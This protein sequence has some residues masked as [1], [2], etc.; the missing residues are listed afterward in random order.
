MFI[1]FFRI[2]IV[3]VIVDLGSWEALLSLIWLF[4]LDLFDKSSLW[5]KM[6]S[7]PGRIMDF[8][9]PS[10]SRAS[11]APKYYITDSY[12]LTHACL[13]THDSTLLMAVTVTPVW[14]RSGQRK[15]L[16][17]CCSLTINDEEGLAA[18]CSLT[19]SH[20]RCISTR[21]MERG[22][23]KFERSLLK[24]G[25]SHKSVLSKQ[26]HYRHPSTV[27]LSYIMAHSS[28]LTPLGVIQH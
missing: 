25:S 8:L 12:F 5:M 3:E 13:S 24:R 17:C 7:I 10:L 9:H 16:I 14:S 4:S 6:T 1:P 28:Q 22:E 11:K 2:N 21:W 27:V 15:D 23:K 26:T 18:H 20:I 19:F